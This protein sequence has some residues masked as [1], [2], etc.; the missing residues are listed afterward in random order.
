MGLSVKIHDSPYLTLSNIPLHF[1]KIN[2]DR[3]VIF[4]AE[5]KM[6]HAG[7]EEHLCM[8]Q[9]IGYL[10]SNLNDF[11]NLVKNG[12]FVCKNCGRVAANDKNLCAPE[13]L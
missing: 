8:L 9:N 3:E 2:S 6:P 12:R 13:K 11:K 4:M 1:Y 7:H 5:I 10:K